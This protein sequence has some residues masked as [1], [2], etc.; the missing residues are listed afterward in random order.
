MLRD[1]QENDV[2]DSMC[3]L[4]SLLKTSK[5]LRSIMLDRCLLLST[6]T[7]VDLCGLC[8]TW[9]NSHAVRVCPNRISEPIFPNVGIIALHFCDGA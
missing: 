2:S 7:Y 6:N 1:L 5:A 4:Q 8:S 3:K 9:G